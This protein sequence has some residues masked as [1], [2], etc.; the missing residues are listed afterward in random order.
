[1]RYRIAICDDE[2][3]ILRQISE[4]LKQIEAEI[5]DQYDLFF[6]ASGDD[7]LLHM[8]RNVHLLFL[9]IGMQ[10]TSGM[11]AAKRLREEGSNALIFFITSMVD[12][13]LQGYSVHAFS[14]L[15]KPILFS[16]FRRHFLDALNQTE[17]EHSE[18][19]A[20]DTLTGKEILL[21]SNIFYV[22]V[23]QHECVFSTASTQYKTVT[24]LSDV[25]KR[26]TI[27]KGFFRCHRSYLVNMKRI[28]RIDALSVTMGNGAVIPLSKYRRKDFLDSYS[29]Y[30]GVRL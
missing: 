29:Y 12:Y 6:Y 13:A 23:F 16:E 9:D 14:F 21:L 18:V 17:R 5:G 28:Q 11:D 1:M 7:L 24:Q 15:S 19:I 3:S 26:L 2:L 27:S 20:L 30:M 8:P 25:E 10:G 4:Y 22:E